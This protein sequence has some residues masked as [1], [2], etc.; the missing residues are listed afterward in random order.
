MRCQCRCSHDQ[1]ASYRSRISGPLLDRIDLH[2]E[3]APVSADE[4]VDAAPGECSAAVRARVVSARAR[5]TERFA[6][7]GLRCN[8]DLSGEQV[9]EAARARPQ[10]LALLRGF[11][12]AHGLSGRAH[13]RLL[14]VGRTIADLEGAER[15]ERHHL[16]EALQYRDILPSDDS[17]GQPTALPRE[18]EPASRPITHLDP[19]GRP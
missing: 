17:R 7:S 13:A 4:L 18:Q 5:Q 8:A 2:V 19:G 16:A 10:A 3:L 6:D 12:E 9:R 15:V 11:I 14:K 1:I